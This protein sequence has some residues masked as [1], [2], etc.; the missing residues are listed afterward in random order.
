MALALS[1]LLSSVWAQSQK[2]EVMILGSFHF[3]FPNL[4]V[5]K[6]AKD[7]Q[8]DVL[9]PKYQKEIEDIVKRLAQF[10]PTIIAIEREPYKQAKYDSLYNLYLKGNYPLNRREEEQF[11]FRLAKQFGLKK[12]YCVDSWSK[13]NEDIEK[14]VDKKDTAAN[15]QFMDFFYHNPEFKQ[16]FL[17]T[18]IFKTQGILAELRRAND[19]E[20]V[21]K[22]LG[23]YLI[24]IFKYETKE[25]EFFG[26]DFVTGWG[27]NRN[28]R[29]F[30]NIQ[31][32]NAKPTDR[33]LIIYGWGHL[34]F[35]NPL[36]ESSPDYK[37]V[38]ASDYL[39]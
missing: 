10:K 21:K 30:R 27:Y 26:P 29:I 18:P 28:L 23:N 3:G 8:I 32:I 34:S 7:D 2:T 19:P 16:Q 33:I 39:K 22:G 14:V 1:F 24:S 4:D 35:L 20:F 25:N 11:G 12:V 5:S 38:K 6:V 15:R 37:L 13:F 36:F 31:R 9:E 17:P